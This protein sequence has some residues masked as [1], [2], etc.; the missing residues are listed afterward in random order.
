[1]GYGKTGLYTPIV[2]C[3]ERYVKSQKHATGKF[4]SPSTSSVFPSLPRKRESRGVIENFDNLALY[5][6]EK[7]GAKT[8]AEHAG[9]E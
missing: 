1:M 6:A 2:P 3:Y 9:I 8:V 4:T 5:N 7:K